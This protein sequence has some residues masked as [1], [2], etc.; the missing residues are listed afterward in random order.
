MLL[1]LLQNIRNKP[2]EIRKRILFFLTGFLMLIITSFWLS[3]IREQFSIAQGADYLQGETITTDDDTV[4][5]SPFSLFKKKITDFGSGA[6]NVF[7]SIG[8]GVKVYKRE[9]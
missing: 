7:S 6:A 3:G 4:T 1:E 2:E 9:K 8:G 5:V